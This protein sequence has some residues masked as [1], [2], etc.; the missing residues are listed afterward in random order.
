MIHTFYMNEGR[1]VFS[2]LHPQLP[3]SLPLSSGS[4]NNKNTMHS[5]MW[6]MHI[7]EDRGAFY[8]CRSMEIPLRPLIQPGWA[9]DQLYSTHEY[10]FFNSHYI[11]INVMKWGNFDLTIKHLIRKQMKH[12]TVTDPTCNNNFQSVHLTRMRIDKSD[13]R[14]HFIYYCHIF[15]V[16]DY[17]QTD[18]VS[19]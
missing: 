7:D 9:K 6:T 19:M 2:L 14:V 11:S 18:E 10:Q 4:N 1:E 17:S 8:T 12:M 5:F 3:S 15:E 13:G 16:D